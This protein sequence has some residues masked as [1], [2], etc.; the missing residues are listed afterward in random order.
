MYRTN[1]KKLG[2]SP[3]AI[4]ITIYFV[5]WGGRGIRPRKE[6]VDKLLYR[7]I[8]L[9]KRIFFMLILNIKRTFNFPHPLKNWG[10]GISPP[11]PGYQHIACTRHCIV[12]SVCRRYKSLCSF[13]FKFPSAAGGKKIRVDPSPRSRLSSFVGTGFRASVPKSF[14]TSERQT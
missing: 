6:I 2:P 11:P 14:Q 7:T 9:R 3:A 1:T 8:A 13:I 10:P 5:R 12:L 4:R